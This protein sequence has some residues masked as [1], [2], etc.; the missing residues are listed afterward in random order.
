[1]L[2]SILLPTFDDVIAVR[3]PSASADPERIQM[4]KYKPQVRLSYRREKGQDGGEL[5][6]LLEFDGY[7]RGGARSTGSRSED[8]TWQLSVP[9]L[10]QDAGLTEILRSI[11]LDRPGASVLLEPVQSPSGQ[12]LPP[13]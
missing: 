5:I 10:P 7:P 6:L 13:H 1:M 9:L 3:G 11:G 8:L 2:V 12:P 4:M